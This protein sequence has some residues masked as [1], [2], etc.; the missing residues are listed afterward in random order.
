M[1]GGGVEGERGVGPASRARR[2]LWVNF[3]CPRSD[4]G[5]V[6]LSLLSCCIC[7]RRLDDNDDGQL[8]NFGD[9]SFARF[10]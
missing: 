1:S 3:T 10:I 7:F 6:S 2:V 8:R 9:R 5:Q 4:I